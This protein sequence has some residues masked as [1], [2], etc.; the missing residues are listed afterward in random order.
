M[1]DQGIHFI[2]KTIESLTQEFKVHHQKST[3]YHSDANGTVEAFNNILETTLTNICSVNK[4]DWDL[5]ILVVLW[6]Y[7]T[8]CKNLTTQ[9]PFKL[10]YGLEAVVPMEYFVPSLRIAAF[11]GMDDTII[12]Q[13]RL[14]HLM[15]LEEYRFIAGFHQ[16]VQKE[17]EKAYHDR[18][19]KKKAFKQGDLV[20]LYDNKFMKH[21]G[22]FRTHWLGP[23]KVSYVTEGGDA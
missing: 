21:P 23:F 16:Q 2:K 11:I 19:I 8:T 10:V 1:S 14:A 17:R 18:H 6:A 5:R 13:D 15:E 7:Q 9:T 22:K 3:P 12:V 20:L 4:D